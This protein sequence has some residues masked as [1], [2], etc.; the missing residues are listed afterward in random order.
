MKIP[1][2]IIKKREK[3]KLKEYKIN[4]NVKKKNLIS[5][6]NKAHK[7]KIKKIIKNC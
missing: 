3:D 4:N 7:V 2:K 5:K 1:T 6:N